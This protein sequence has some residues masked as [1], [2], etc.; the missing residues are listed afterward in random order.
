M[1]V[2][3]EWLDVDETIAVV[4]YRG[5]WTWDEAM[6]ANGQVAAMIAAKPYRCDIIGNFRMGAM[7]SVRPAIQNARQILAGMPANIGLIV[8]ITN[9]VVRMLASVY[10]SR[11]PVMG[12]KLRTASSVE[13][14][15]DLIMQDRSVSRRSA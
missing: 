4:E 12:A 5:G 3:S 8:V 6:R 1:P 11:D 13:A 2:T 7:E 14:A 9:P 10:K 15:R